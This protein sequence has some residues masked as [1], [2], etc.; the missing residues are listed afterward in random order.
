MFACEIVKAVTFKLPNP[1]TALL[2][3]T[4]FDPALIVRFGLPVP[5][6]VLLN[7]NDPVVRVVGDAVSCTAAGNVT[8]VLL[9][10]MLAPIL[11]ALGVLPKA[12]LLAKITPVVVKAPVV[13]KVSVLNW[14]SAVPI[15]GTVRAALPG[16]NVTDEL[17]ALANF[18][19]V[20]VID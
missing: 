5:F 2:K 16:L 4:V 18:P 6:N 15:A 3:V 11:I 20:K 9:V 17:E 10:V 14:P 19:F 8:A 13:E 1:L 7:V 12:M